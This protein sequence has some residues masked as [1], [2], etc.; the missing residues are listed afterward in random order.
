M[1][2]NVNPIKEILANC[3]RCLNR[4]KLKVGH[5]AIRERQGHRHRRRIEALP[6]A[7]WECQQRKV[8][9]RSC[10]HGI[11]SLAH[12]KTQGQRETTG[13][14]SGRKHE[15]KQP[16]KQSEKQ[17]EN[18]QTRKARTKARRPTKNP[19][20]RKTTTPAIQQTL[21]ARTA[22]RS[23]QPARTRTA[24]NTRVKRAEP[25]RQVSIKL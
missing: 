15:E 21:P 12:R 2:T 1:D 6:G 17:S 18:R 22:Q 3:F 8:A 5:H 10:A 16:D 14:T 23:L 9:R 13:G 4:W 19:P 7:S 24:S 11:S 20:K 25:L